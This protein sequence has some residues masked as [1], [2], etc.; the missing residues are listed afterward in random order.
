MGILFLLI[1]I[2]RFQKV[3][4]RICPCRDRYVPFLLSPSPNAPSSSEQTPRRA[5]RIHPPPNPTP[6]PTLNPFTFTPPNFPTPS[7]EPIFPAY[8]YTDPSRTHLHFS[9][10]FV[11]LLPNPASSFPSLPY[12]LTHLSRIPSLGSIRSSP[13]HFLKLQSLTL[14]SQGPCTPPGGCIRPV[15]T[16][17]SQT[18]EPIR[19]P[20]LD[21]RLVHS[22]SIL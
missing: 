10:P 7:P 18:L 20:T 3:L 5:R 16:P 22:S 17:R 14:K 8:P 9:N 12:M 1:L 11:L 4:F 2:H 6:P 15:R 13:H 19:S 21:P